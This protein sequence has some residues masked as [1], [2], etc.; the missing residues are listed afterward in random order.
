V[1]ISYAWAAGI[2]RAHSLL[3]RFDDERA[4]ETIDGRGDLAFSF[5]VL[6]FFIII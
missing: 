2:W 1:E 4:K 5:F 6:Q 3:M